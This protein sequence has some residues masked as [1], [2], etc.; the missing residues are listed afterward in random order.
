MASQDVYETLIQA[1][2]AKTLTVYEALHEESVSKFVDAVE[3][4]Q[5]VLDLIGSYADGTDAAVAHCETEATGKMFG[6]VLELDAQCTRMAEHLRDRLRQ[7]MGNLRRRKR[8]VGTYGK[9]VD[10]Y[11]VRRGHLKGSA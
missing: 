1:L 10:A 8:V 6:R 9:A 5:K 11:A 4:R 7:E 2:L 3:E